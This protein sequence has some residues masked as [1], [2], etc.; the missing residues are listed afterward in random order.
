MNTSRIV[1][2]HKMSKYE[3]D[4][5]RYR[6]SSRELLSKYKREGVDATRILKSHG[7]QQESLKKVKHLFRHAQFVPY[8][9]MTRALADCAELVVSLGGDNHFQ[10]VSHFVENSLMMGIN[11][12]PVRSE[13][14]LTSF[15]ADKLKSLVDK[16]RKDEFKVQEWTRIQVSIDGNNL[17]SL[18]VSEIFIGESLRSNMSRYR[19]CFKR[20]EQEQKS[21]GL[22]FATGAGSSGWY[23]AAC[24]YIFPKGNRFS[25]QA[26]AFR[27]LVTE[28]Y[29]GRLN[30]IRWVHGTVKQGETLEVVSLNDSSG[31][32]VI[33]AQEPHDFTE[34]R[35]ATLRAGV[36]LRVISFK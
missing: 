15:A 20:R 19:L 33:D 8:T 28:P 35:I 6:L 21:G 25:K 24:R 11:S 14:A 23:D 7:R 36:P 13:G 17:R 34:G 9:K 10:Y 22:L 3:W 4:M 31:V 12:D 32:L 2:C 30:K 26:N 29:H 1:V 18:A 5:Y 27:F 16:I